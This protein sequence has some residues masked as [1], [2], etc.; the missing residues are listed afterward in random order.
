MSAS[1]AKT[2]RRAGADSAERR[3]I[4]TERIIKDKDNIEKF[5]RE[6][7]ETLQ[8]IAMRPGGTLPSAVNETKDAIT[9]RIIH[10]VNMMKEVLQ[11]NLSLRENI[12]KQGE[13][14][15]NLNA[16]IFMLQNENE[17]LRTRLQILEEYTGKDTY[18]DMAKLVKEKKVL[19][20]RVK[21]LEKT[22]MNWAAAQFQ[23]TRSQFNQSTDNMRPIVNSFSQGINT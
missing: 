12:Q 3:L 17:D 16:D 5:F 9:E 22:S 18:T 21:H 19:E 8:N 2:E 15:D 10:T 23:A 6:K 7:S 4:I 1:S 14:I 11:S 20:N 13:H